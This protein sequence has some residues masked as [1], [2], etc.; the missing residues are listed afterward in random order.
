MALKGVASRRVYHLR[1]LLR[2][3][4]FISYQPERDRLNDC[5]AKGTNKLPMLAY[6]ALHFRG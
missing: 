3:D 6:P 5:A 2:L 1:R 4:Y